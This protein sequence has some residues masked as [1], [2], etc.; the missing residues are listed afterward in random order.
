MLHVT[1]FYN[2][3][4]TTLV[5]LIIAQTESTKKIAMKILP[6]LTQI[7][8]SRKVFTA[9]SKINSTY[10]NIPQEEKNSNYNLYEQ[11]EH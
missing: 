5:T 9:L 11:F 8:I 7:M 4:C 1:N 10:Q 6:P 3:T 2:A